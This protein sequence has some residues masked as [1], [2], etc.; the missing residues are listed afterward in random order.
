MRNSL[1]TFIL[2]VFVLVPSVAQ[3]TRGIKDEAS[4]ILHLINKYHPQPKKTDD[5][6]SNYVFKN[7]IEEINTDGLLFLPSE[8]DELSKYQFQIDDE[9]IGS[10]WEFI[11]AVQAQ[12]KISVNRL[13]TL[14][15]A[16]KSKPIDFSAKDSY[17]SHNGNKTI[18]LKTEK[19]LENQVRLWFKYLVLEEMITKAI[20]E[21]KDIKFLKKN[22]SDIR[23]KIADE[24]INYLKEALNDA[25]NEFIKEN[26]L[27]VFTSY[28]DPH[29]SY[30]SLERKE[31][32]ED[33]LSSEDLRFGITLSTDEDQRVIIEKLEPGGAAWKSNQLNSGDRLLKLKWEGELAIDVSELSI[34]EIHKIIS[35]NDKMELTFIVK[36]VNGSIKTIKLRK[37]IVSET[38]DIVKSYLLNGEKKI[39]Y[40]T[41][42]DFYTG[43][44]LSSQKG[45]ANDVAKEVLKL[46]KE[47]IEGIILDVRNNGG[48]SLLEAMNLAGIFI[49][50]GPLCIVSDIG[51]KPFTLKD[52]NRGTIYNGPLI[53]MING[54]SASASELLAASLQDYNRALI[55]GQ[56]TYGKSTGQVVLPNDSAVNFLNKDSDQWLNSTS[57]LKITTSRIYRIT[58]KSAQQKG[59]QPDVVLPDIYKGFYHKEKD[60]PTSLKND[61]IIKKTYY[62]PLKAYPSARLQEA[63]D[64][65]MQSDTIFATIC[66]TRDS[67]LTFV[68]KQKNGIDLH[69]EKMIEREKTKQQLIDRLSQKVTDNSTY[70]VANNAYEKQIIDVDDYLKEQ[71]RQILNDL[72]GDPTLIETYKIMIDLIKLN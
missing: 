66:A 38:V 68:E 71:N 36:K 5:S 35:R 28:F 40:I 41:L 2:V 53:L 47:N 61:S 55:V 29:T 25:D 44:A 32:F 24:E 6:L 34:K 69:L 10:S 46:Q 26:F 65:R 1:L 37:E 18:E 3:T 62:T 58:G 30:F 14:L 27:H 57:F 16:Y 13:I 15:E 63:S 70:S 72:W 60:Y 23:I 4:H 31:T 52:E 59:I 56:T 50:E 45:C 9:L 11:P 39:G 8:L 42:P 19:D 33:M 48:G 67:I 51:T 20:D 12:F 7:F 17:Y 22:E 54:Q 21:E 64:H 43:W 49:S